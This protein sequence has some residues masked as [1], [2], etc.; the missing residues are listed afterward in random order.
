VRDFA[1]RVAVVTGGA[2]GIGRAMARRFAVEGMR[3]V[4][5]DVEEEA[6]E[7]TV[8]A[9]RR[10][11]LDVLGVLTDVASAESVDA[12][13]RRAFDTYGAVHVLCNNAGV[14]G[15]GVGSYVWEHSL[16]DWQWA[17]GVNLWG[18]VHGLNAFVPRML[19]QGDEG[20]IVNTASVA[21][22]VSGARLDV[23]GAT[24][25]AVVRVSEALHLQL[26]ELGARLHASVLCPGYVQ[27]RIGR[28]VRNRPRA[29]W[30]GAPPSRAALERQ[31]RE[32]E[33]VMR[34]I[35]I[36]PEDVADQVLEA[37]RE[38]RFWILTHDG[39][40]DAIR[41][42]MES[43]LGRTNPVSVQPAEVPSNGPERRFS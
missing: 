27:T 5:A 35:G 39:F 24:K 31:T 12:L 29:L 9:L 2:S 17:F 3:V 34:E 37:V 30:D 6:L 10:D 13:A 18:V 1:G 21:G 32:A 38:E 19:A 23:Y 20:H 42:R 8:T 26:T 11:E 7:A 16:K 22:L 15:G 28:S 14:G 43:I 41:R 40:D 25:H 36:P 33:A 4:L